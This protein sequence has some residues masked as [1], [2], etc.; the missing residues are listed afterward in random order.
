MKRKITITK[1]AVAQETVLPT[2]RD[3]WLGIG[4]STGPADRVKAEHGVRAAYKAGGLQ[5]PTFIMWL[6][7]P[8]AGVLGQAVAPEIVAAALARLPQVDAQVG[9]QVDAQV[10]DQ[11]YGQVRDQ[12]YDQVR[13]QVYDQVGAQV[14]DQVRDQV[15]AQ[16]D[17]Q[18][19]DQVYGQVRAQVYDQVRAQVDAQVYDQV[20]DQVDAQVDAQVGAQ[21]RAQVRA[22]VDDQV[23]AQVDD[24]V[25][26]QVRD[27]VRAQVRAQVGAQVYKDRINNWWNGRIWG[28]YLAG[29]YSYLDAMEQLGVTGL[30][31]IH[32]QQEIAQAGGGFWWCFRDFAVLTPRSLTLHR[33]PEGNLHNP[34]GPAMVW[35][36]GWAVYSW[37]GVRVPADLIE[38]GWDT[39]RIMREENTEIRRCAIERMGWDRFVIDARLQL[40]DTAPDPANAPNELR[41]YD[42]PA[43]IYGERVRVVLM[44]N[45]S[46]DRDGSVR[47]YGETV[48]ASI[49][50]AVEAQAWAWD[51]PASEYA[52]LQRA[53]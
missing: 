5:P 18:V 8:G 11:V 4:L 39:N 7:S 3:T 44:V 19:Y 47:R 17:A 31:P 53:T 49:C 22:Q 33:D 38:T 6:D 23:G 1:L 21:V 30:E 13:D 14:Y 29:W 2:T 32:G 27:Q 24:Q 26:A 45:A 52:A 46:P 9:A 36:D 37:H 43:E 25:D 12:V 48:P 10:Y 28:Q 51:L 34:D 35:P 42:I 50:T 20:Y 40:V 15:R 16:V 41:L